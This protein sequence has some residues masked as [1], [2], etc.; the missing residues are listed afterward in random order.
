[1]YYLT[2]PETSPPAFVFF[3]NDHRLV[4]ASYERYLEKQLRRV[5]GFQMAPLRL[6]FRTSEG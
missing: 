1:M 3:V 6:V 2:Q 4:T 5:F